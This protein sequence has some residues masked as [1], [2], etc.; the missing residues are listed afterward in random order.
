MTDVNQDELLEIEETARKIKFY[1][2]T[3]K[4]HSNNVQ[5]PRSMARVQHDCLL[6]ARR[7]DNSVDIP[8]EVGEEAMKVFE[9]RYKL[10]LQY[11]AKNP[12]GCRYFFTA[13]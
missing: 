12:I 1:Q 9:S 7:G 8:W 10:K 3:I 4:K 6:A 2:D 11:F 5:M 13:L